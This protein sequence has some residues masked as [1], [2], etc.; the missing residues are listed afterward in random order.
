MHRKFYQVLIVSDDNAE[1][2]AF[3][4]PVRRLKFLKII[5]IVLGVHLLLGIVGYVLLVNVYQK[6][7]ELVSLNKQLEANNQRIHELS[8]I[9]QEL[10]NSQTKMRTALGLGE[11]NVASNSSVEPIL[12]APDIVPDMLPVNE[13]NFQVYQPNKMN[14]QEKLGFLQ[15]SKSGIHE[16]EKSI[17][18][19]LPVEGVLT[20]DFQQVKMDGSIEHRGID[21]AAQRGAFVK[22]AADGIVI[23]SGW[24]YDLGNLVIVSHGN[25][26]RTYYGHN[27]RN[28]VRRNASVRKGD[29]IAL[30]GS[31]GHSSAPHLHFEI[32]KDGISLDPKDYILA[33]SGL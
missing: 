22:V 30:L 24:T 15:R 6:N 25:G 4:I 5:A 28:M 11:L 13:S 26:F 16:Y 17:P 10:E 1:P 12:E 19:L 29:T 21:I 8:R 32:W 14:N 23:F 33:F 9:F 18:T 2:K 27:Q 20:T 3:T 7:R 31:S